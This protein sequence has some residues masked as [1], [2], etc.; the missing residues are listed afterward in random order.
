G[1]RRIWGRL[2]AVALPG[3]ALATPGTAVHY[4]GA[5]PMGSPAPQGTNRWGELNAASGVYVVDGAA[6]PTLPS[7]YSTL[8]IMANADR[9]GRYIA[10]TR[11]MAA[12]DGAM[13]RAISLSIR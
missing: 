12:T 4:A 5:L 8:T 9:V 6:L 2:G 10:Q 13:S 1:V 11:S 3:T 7:K